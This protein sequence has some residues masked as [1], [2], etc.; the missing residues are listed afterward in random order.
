MQAKIYLDRAGVYLR[1][2]MPNDRQAGWLRTVG[3]EHTP[4][5]AVRERRIAYA[6][7]LASV[8]GV[9]SEVTP[10]DPDAGVDM[11]HAKRDA[12]DEVTE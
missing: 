12:N 8:L 11:M 1:V 2:E 5:T 7:T 6:E 3:A 10:A 9:P 4:V